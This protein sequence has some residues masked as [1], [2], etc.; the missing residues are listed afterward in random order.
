[1]RAVGVV[2][3]LLAALGMVR[4]RALASAA[5]VRS[6]ADA[7]LPLLVRLAAARQ[8]V[9]GLALLTRSPVDVRRSAGLFLPLTAL[10]AAAVLLAQQQG[11]LRPRSVV[12]ATTVLATNVVVAVRSR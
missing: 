7:S 4:P 5:G 8:A 10:D 2:S 11:V 12:M 9:L 6:S 1:M 3:L